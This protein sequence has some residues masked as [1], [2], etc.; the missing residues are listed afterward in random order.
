MGGYRHWDQSKAPLLGTSVNKFKHMLQRVDAKK[1]NAMI[2]ES[3][4]DV[5]VAATYGVLGFGDSDDALKAE[6]MAEEI[7]FED[8]SKVDLRVV[9]ITAAEDVKEANKLLK[10]T[11]SLGGNETRTVFAGIKQAY[12]PKTLVGRQAVMVAN[13]A[14]RKMRFGVSEGM[15]V[16]S[17]PGGTDVFL[18]S[19]DEGAVPG[20]RVH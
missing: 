3:K 8:F 19:P 10:L 12:D 5:D 2:Q 7:S 15:I 1:I 4:E 9:R 16:A 6:P 14:P 18:L 13:L 11:L 20:Q 17:G